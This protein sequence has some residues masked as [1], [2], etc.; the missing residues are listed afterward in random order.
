M[1][2][3]HVHGNYLYYLSQI[4]HDIYVP[5]KQDRSAGYA[6]RAGDFPWPP[7]LHEVPFQKVR[8]LKLDCL[9]F[10]SEQHYLQDQYELLSP[11]QRRLPKIYLEH[12]PPRQSP[13][14]TIH[15]ASNSN[16]T[17]IVHVTP[18]NALMWDTKDSPT[19]IIEHGVTIPSKVRYTGELARGVVV[20][21][22]LARRGRRLGADVFETVRK[23]IPLDLVGIGAEEL[24]GLGEIS[25]PNLPEFISRYRFFFNPIRYTSLGLA[26]CEAMMAGLPVVSLATT[27]MVTTIKNGESGYI[28][29]KI[30]SLIKHMRLLLANPDSARLLGLGARRAAH[31]RFNIERFIKDWN[32]TLSIAVQPQLRTCDD[33]R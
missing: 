9:V 12:D 33:P 31:A 8:D 19:Y 26:V 30:E 13:T 23:E 27:E 24:G 2:T 22:N 32:T 29:T 21:N 6:G 1:L 4:P 20:V 3:W 10:Q 15:V 17:L 25:P 7:N 18:F 16:D 14:D 5:V 28:D 11:P